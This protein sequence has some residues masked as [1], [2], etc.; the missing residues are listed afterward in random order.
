MKERVP[1]IDLR[2]VQY[3]EDIEKELEELVYQI[4]HE[5]KIPKKRRQSDNSEEA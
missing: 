3:T 4:E 1:P 5:R 2:G